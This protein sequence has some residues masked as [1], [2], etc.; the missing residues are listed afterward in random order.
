MSY[1]PGITALG[2]GLPGRYLIDPRPINAVNKKKKLLRARHE[3]HTARIDPKPRRLLSSRPSSV[4]LRKRLCVKGARTTRYEREKVRKITSISV[5]TAARVPSTLCC[6]FVIPKWLRITFWSE[7]KGR[8]WVLL[9]SI[10][11]PIP[12]Q[13]V[14]FRAGWLFTCRVAFSCF[15]AFTYLQTAYS[16]WPLFW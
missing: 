4:D 9:R 5:H 2:K 1:I 10:K 12:G 7:R 6:L 3:R 14:H 11:R 16:V 8:F 15:Q 13:P